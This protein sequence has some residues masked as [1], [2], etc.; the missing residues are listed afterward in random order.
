MHIA[1]LT[2]F[3]FMSLGVAIQTDSMT[4]QKSES[5]AF[6]VEQLE[7]DNDAAYA[8]VRDAAEAAGFTIYPIMYG[9]AKAKLGLVE[10][11]P[12]GQGK[13]RKRASPARPRAESASP[14][15]DFSA[16]GLSSLE[17]VIQAMKDSESARQRYRH[18]LEQIGDIIQSALDDR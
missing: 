13:N 12:R 10:T 4:Q 6:V 11:R 2:P 1:S 7:R 16:G 18:A 15:V 17:A 14:P 5:F 8:T 9:R 3:G